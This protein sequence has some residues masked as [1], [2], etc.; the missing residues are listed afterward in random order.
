[1]RAIAYGKDQ[2]IRVKVVANGMCPHTVK[3]LKSGRTLRCTLL[4]YKKWV[5][6]LKRKYR[7]QFTAA[8][9][10]MTRGGKGPTIE[11]V[12]MMLGNLCSDPKI[13]CKVLPA[14]QWK[15]AVR[16]ANVDLP[17][18]YKW[19]KVTPH[20]LDACLIGIYMCSVL[21]GHKGFDGLD[22]KKLMKKLVLQMEA[23]S[24]ARLI[25]RKTRQ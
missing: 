25:N 23:T 15:N 20:Q 19:A 7:V 14:A 12:N 2:K 17:K 21:Y 5:T 16:R 10:F 6:Q 1:V 3:E 18:W 22:L 4:T 13:P 11:A 9:R 24:Q 8:E